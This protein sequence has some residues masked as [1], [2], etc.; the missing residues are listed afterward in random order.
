L[1]STRVNRANLQRTWQTGAIVSKRE[2]LVEAATH[3]FY[4]DGFHA[5]GVD[6]ILDEAGVAKMTLYKHFKSKD[7][8]ILEVLETRSAAFRGWL[9]E[10][11]ERRAAQPRDRLLALFDVLDDWI[12][13]PGFRG[14]AFVNV[15]AEYGDP[16]APPHRAAA[17]HKHGVGAYLRDLAAAAGA[18][19]P[20]H[21]AEQLM[22]LVEGAISL[23]NVAG[24]KSAARHARAAAAVLVDHALAA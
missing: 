4:R 3:L 23:A 18:P 16:E 17:A 20:A 8:L 9:I 14:C 11:V 12:H 13:Q 24:R 10:E 19:D 6:R 7:D 5:T 15:A 2:Q 21:L 22:L 1:E